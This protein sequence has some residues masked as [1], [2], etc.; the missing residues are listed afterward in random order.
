MATITTRTVKPAG[1]GDYTSLAAWRA[2]RVSGDFV[3]RI[4][5]AEC[6]AGDAGEVSFG[7]EPDSMDS[8]SLIEIVAAENDRHAGKWDD[9]KARATTTNYYAV[10]GSKVSGIRIH[11]TG[12]LLRGARAAVSGSRPTY[13]LFGCICE[14]TLYNYAPVDSAS[15]YNCIAYTLSATKGSQCFRAYVSGAFEF[16]NCT[17]IGKAVGFYSGF[18]N[19]LVKN[20]LS[21]G[22]TDGFSGTFVE[23]SDYNCSDVASDAPGANSKTG[24]VAFKNSANNDYHLAA[25][26]TVARGAGTNLTASG[27]TDDIDGETRP[28]IGAWDI[29]ADQYVAPSAGPAPKPFGAYRNGAKAHG[30]RR[31]GVAA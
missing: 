10:S 15:A 27:I 5:R 30:V 22:C 18:S 28:A 9:T 11:I 21:Q 24:T 25:T 17:A 13:Y 2:A 3:D 8:T 19:V 20:C 6:Y 4:E 1:G 7:T 23:G 12:M 14:N 29:G 31:F 26:D 16:I